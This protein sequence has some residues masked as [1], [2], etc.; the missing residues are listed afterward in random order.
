MRAALITPTEAK[1]IGFDAKKS[2]V[3]VFLDVTGIKE[4]GLQRFEIWFYGGKS[5]EIDILKQY[6][7]S[8]IAYK[9][10]QL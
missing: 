6:A 8:G 7:Q 4:S 5:T 2:N 9:A 10:F 3:G 1:K